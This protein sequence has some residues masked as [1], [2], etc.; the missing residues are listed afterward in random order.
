MNLRNETVTP[1]FQTM[2]AGV[3]AAGDITGRSNLETVAAKE[4]S[5]AKPHSPSN[6]D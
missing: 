5:L 6:L 1:N 3:F 2:V 4:G